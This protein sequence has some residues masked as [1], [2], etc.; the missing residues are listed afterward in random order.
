FLLLAIV[1]SWVLVW[2]C[3]LP[4][5]NDVTEW[6]YMHYVHVWGV[7]FF[8]AS[9]T[10]T[11]IILL[12]GIV[13]GFFIDANKFSLHAI[14]RNRLIRAYLGASRPRDER[15]PNKFTGFDPSDDFKLSDLSLENGTPKGP[16]KRLFHVINGTLNLVHGEELAWQE[17]KAESF[18]M[19]PLHC[20]SCG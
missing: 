14:Y 17:R 10:L 19:T 6:L 2:L 16:P 7:A 4:L 12:V 3:S 11:V 5:V 9:I 18:T 1:I 20:G 15:K 13:M 8:V